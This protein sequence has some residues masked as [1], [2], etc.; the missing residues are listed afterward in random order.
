MAG[1][2]R[3]QVW[4]EAA[5]EHDGSLY[6]QSACDGDYCP[7][8]EAHSPTCK[9]PNISAGEAWFAEYT[10]PGYMDRT[11]PV[12]STIG[13]IDA[14]REAFALFGDDTDP[15]ERRELAQVIRQA[16]AQGFRR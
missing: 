16:R 5:E 15:E 7:A 11:D 4:S 12:V 2:M 6:P 1:H 14:A 13:P 3:L 8:G 10:A 9:L